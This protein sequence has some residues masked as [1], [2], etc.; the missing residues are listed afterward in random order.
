MQ[1]RVHILQEYIFAGCAEGNFVRWGPAGALQVSGAGIA[2]F[3]GVQELLFMLSKALRVDKPGQIIL[4]IVFNDVL[5]VESL[6]VNGSL[7]RVGDLYE[8]IVIF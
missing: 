8:D 2:N 3:Q 1:E 6:V 5:E 4:I 7:L